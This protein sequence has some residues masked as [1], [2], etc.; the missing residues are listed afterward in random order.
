MSATGKSM[1]LRSTGVVYAQRVLLKHKY[2]DHNLMDFLSAHHQ[3]LVHV[4]RR[5][6]RVRLARY[7]HQLIRAN[8]FNNPTPKKGEI[9]FGSRLPSQAILSPVSDPTPTMKKVY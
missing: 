4:S 2:V 6:S 7:Q 9:P 8:G 5:S 1:L 3:P